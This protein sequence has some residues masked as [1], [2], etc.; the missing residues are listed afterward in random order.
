MDETVPLSQGGGSGVQKTEH[1]GIRAATVAQ[2]F[3]T[4]CAAVVAPASDHTL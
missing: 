3:L 4:V 1:L 2:P